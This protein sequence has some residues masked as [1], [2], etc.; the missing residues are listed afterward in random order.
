MLLLVIAVGWPLVAF[1]V[2]AV[3]RVGRGR[4]PTLADLVLAEAEAAIVEATARRVSGPDGT[5]GQ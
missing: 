2:G 4:P 5:V 3:I 1:L